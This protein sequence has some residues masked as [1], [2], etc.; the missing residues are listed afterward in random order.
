LREME[1]CERCEGICMRDGV[2]LIERGNE[3]LRVRKEADIGLAVDGVRGRPLGSSQR[4]RRLA[5]VFEGEPPSSLSVWRLG[6]C[7]VIE[8]VLPSHAQAMVS[9]STHRTPLSSRRIDPPFTRCCPFDLALTGLSIPIDACGCILPLDDHP[10]A[11]LLLDTSSRSFLSSTN[12]SSS[13]LS[14]VLPTSQL[15]PTMPFAEIKATHAKLGIFT[16]LHKYAQPIPFFFLLQ[17]GRAT[18]T[19]PSTPSPAGSK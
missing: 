9:S 14:S 5:E 16:K 2:D 6:C 13:L 8:L 7:I 11:S 3:G 17:P 18:L 15:L 1:R 19:R 4:E 12:L 10:D